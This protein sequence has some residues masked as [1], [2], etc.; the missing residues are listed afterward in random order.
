[1]FNDRSHQNRSIFNR[2]VLR[3]PNYQYVRRE[4]TREE[5]GAHLQNQFSS[6]CVGELFLNPRENLPKSTL[7][8]LRFCEQQ[9]KLDHGVSGGGE[10]Q[11]KGRI[12]SLLKSWILFKRSSHG[13]KH[14]WFCSKIKIFKGGGGGGIPFGQRER[15]RSRMGVKIFSPFEYREVLRQRTE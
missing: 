15:K 3:S 10:K 4:R 12:T 5:R 11:E 7:L 2:L 13:P 1:M 9:E 8:K 6:F 14:F